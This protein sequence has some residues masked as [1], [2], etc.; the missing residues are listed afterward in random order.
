MQDAYGRKAEEGKGATDDDNG[1][2]GENKEPGHSSR[3]GRVATALSSWR[4]AVRGKGRNKN[5]KE[6]RIREE[7]EAAGTLNSPSQS[8]NRIPEE[9]PRGLVVP[10]RRQ[11][12]MKAVRC[13]ANVRQHCRMNRP[14]SGALSRMGRISTRGV[15]IRAG[16]WCYSGVL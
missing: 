4:Y 5:S 9:T 6:R 2:F 3:P 12:C 14:K 8:N 1:A 13:Y 11:V 15:N 10:W 7:K 16:T